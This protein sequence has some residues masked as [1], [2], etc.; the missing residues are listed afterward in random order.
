M[1]KD[2]MKEIKEAIE[3]RKIIEKAN[4]SEYGI[5]NVRSSYSFSDDTEIVTE[6]EAVKELI[7][8]EEESNG[9]KDSN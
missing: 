1:A 5:P 8:R 3:L 9:K 2:K 6:L 4:K 7:A